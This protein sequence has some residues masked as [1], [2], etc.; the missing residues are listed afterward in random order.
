MSAVTNC[1]N[2]KKKLTKH[3]DAVD[4]L[5]VWGKGISGCINLDEAQMSSMFL[6]DC[7]GDSG[8]YAK[9]QQRFCLAETTEALQRKKKKTTPLEPVDF[10]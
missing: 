2:K 4:G 9:K 8:D 7:S 1:Q 3:F 5:I 10:V 6:S